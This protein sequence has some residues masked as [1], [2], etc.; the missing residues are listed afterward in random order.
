MRSSHELGLGCERDQLLGAQGDS[1]YC[2]G[3]THKGS[4]S[5]AVVPVESR[6]GD[7]L[8]VTSWVQIPRDTIQAGV[9]WERV[10]WHGETSDALS[11]LCPVL[12]G[13]AKGPWGTES[14]GVSSEQFWLLVPHW[15][16]GCSC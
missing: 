3:L 4:C 12:E 15:D 14:P 10:V 9:T 16:H 2:L 7:V 5:E 8:R 13:P 6:P 1:L 11:C